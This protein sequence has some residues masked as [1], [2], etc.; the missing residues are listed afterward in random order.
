MSWLFSRDQS[1]IPL[2]LQVSSRLYLTLDLGEQ[3]VYMVETTKERLLNVHGTKSSA[4]LATPVVLIVFNRAQ[5]TRRVFQAIAEARPR[6]LLVIAD[7]PRASRPHEGKLCDEVRSVIKRVD[8]PCDVLTNF[9]ESN[10]GCCER[11]VTG[12]NWAFTH[13]EEAIILEDDCLPHIDFFRFCQ[14]LL[15]RYRGDSRIGCISGNNIDPP[16]RSTAYS[17]H[18]SQLGTTWGWATWRTAWQ[19]CDL[20]MRDWPAVRASSILREVLPNRASLEYWTSIF[21]S[22]H[23]HTGPDTW[24]YQWLYSRLVHGMLSIVPGVNL[25]RNIGFGLDATHTFEPPK[26]ADGLVECAIDFPLKHP[27]YVIPMRSFDSLD[28][29]I[30]FPPVTTTKRLIRKAH[31]VGRLVKQSLSSVRSL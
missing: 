10:L 27:P 11:V 21:E 30:G 24:D 8:W 3:T 1:T 7:G 31:G 16:N 6:Q 5:P 9:S 26:W 22:M 28:Q 4:Q 14:E 15:E 17:Y 23:D 18:F 2:N 13:V 29:Q 19:K 12:L 20:Q 25:V